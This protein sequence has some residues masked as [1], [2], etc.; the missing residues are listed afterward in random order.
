MNKHKKNCVGN[1]LG[2]NEKLA[3]DWDKQKL[4]SPLV[5]DMFHLSVHFF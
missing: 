4:F 3:L 1:I 5:Y 2:K